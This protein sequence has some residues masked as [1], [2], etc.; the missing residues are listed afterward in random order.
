MPRTRDGGGRGA[1]GGR[2]RTGKG[3][4]GRRRDGDGGTGRA[5]RDGGGA[6]GGDGRRRGRDESAAARRAAGAAHLEETERAARSSAR[7]R[8]VRRLLEGIGT[9]ARTEFKPDPFQLEA[10]AALEHEDVLVTAPTGSGKTWIAREEIRRLLAAGKRAWYTSPLKAL[11]NSKYQEFSEAFGAEHVGILT[12][13]R[14]ER[15]DAPLIV[16][17]TEV[18]R[19]QLFDALREGRELRTD[20]VIMDEAHYLADEERGHVWEE[21]IILTPPRVRLL[22]LSATVGNAEDFAAWVAEVRGVRCGVVTR[23]GARPVPLRAAFLYPEGQIAPLFDEAGRFNAEVEGFLQRSSAPQRHSSNRWGERHAPQRGGRMQMPEMPPAS[24]LSALQSYDLLPAIVFL[25]TRRRCDEAA[26][27]AALGRRDT[28]AARRDARRAIMRDFVA[29]HTEISKHRHWDTILRGGV[30]SHHAGHLPAW[31]LLIE[32]LMSAGLLDAIFATATV[33]AGVDFPARTVVLSNIDVRRG[34]GWRTL[35]ASEF[36]QMTGRAGRRGR[37]RVGFIVA[38][39]GTH[40]DPQKMAALLGALPDPLESQFR[41]TYTTLLNLLDAY[42]NFAQVREIAARSFAHRETVERVARLEHERAEA[43]R[44]IARKLTEAGYGEFATGVVRGLER[45]ASARDRVMSDAPQTRTELFLNWL[46]EA[47]VPGRVV[48]IGR[49]S[50]RLVFVT[51]QRGAGFVGVRED[52]RRA[53]LEL[54]RVGRVYE[55]VY[56]LTENAR[57]AAFADVRAGRAT[58]MHEPRLRDARAGTDEAVDV[59][60]DLMEQLTASVV[61]GTAG[62]ASGDGE[63]ARAA[64][65]SEVED[66][67]RRAEEALWAALPDAEAAERA[68]RRIEVLRAEVWQPFERRARVLEH[69]GYLDFAAERVTERGRWLADLR[70]D[71]PLLVGEAIERNL[72]ASLDAARAAG[73]MAA[74]AADAERDYGELQ[75]DDALV[76]TLAEFERIAYEVAGVEWKQGLDPAP[77]M[78]FSAAA[79]VTRW[80]RGM[81]WEELVRQTRAEEGDLFRLL[82]RTGESL[83]QIGNLRESHAAAAHVAEE[84]AENILR[85]PVRS[86]ELL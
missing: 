86:E 40:Q 54:T 37:D 62:A 30:A 36:Q 13:D 49:S 32:K 74:L 20:L 26:A 75:L 12:G 47:V 22:L 29:E 65:S 76:S 14:K 51:E 59:I 27:E 52:G 9:P 10:F 1:G 83:M 44:R 79:A 55:E 4:G 5:R 31:K 39:P 80:A 7:S 45:L 23:P 11:T 19:N 63:A 33:A 46:L 28:D 17:T 56:P 82:S 34:Q 25:P 69:F 71:R 73:L 77:E 81:K 15:A 8:P 18:Y 48:G 64:E 78:N 70:L 43:E 53:S 2:R 68:E 21:A 3:A 84:A 85:E 61:K 41:A 58:L 57:D 24:L 35:T 38:A 66:A 60:N 42:G 50:R 16:G 6:G 72:F 67:R